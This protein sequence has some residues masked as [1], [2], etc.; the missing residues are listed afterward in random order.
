MSPLRQRLSVALFKKAGWQI[1]DL[2]LIEA[3]EAFAAQA[4]AVGKE[5]KWD[6]S[7][8]NVNGGAIA[9]GHPL[10]KR[11]PTQAD[12]VCQNWDGQSL[13]IIR[14]Y[15]VP[16]GHRRPCLCCMKQSQRAT[17]GA[18]NID[19]YIRPCRADECND[20]RMDA[21]VDVYVSDMGLQCRYLGCV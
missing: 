3:N 11:I 1:S 18:T 5:L 4:L 16:S 21:W 15:V 19:T 9:L 7:K 8:V 2:D 13:H 6:A 20:I 14:D 10:C 17:R 12:A